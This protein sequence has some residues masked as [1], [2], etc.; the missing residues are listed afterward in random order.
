MESIT[1]FPGGTLSIAP[2]YALAISIESPHVSSNDAIQKVFLIRII[3][4]E[5]KNPGSL[6]RT[7][8]KL[9]TNLCLSV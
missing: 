7:G 4:G 1:P 5:N 9:I 3:D 6:K 2:N 8:V